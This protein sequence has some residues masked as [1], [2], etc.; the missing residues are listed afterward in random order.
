MKLGMYEYIMLHEPI[1]AEY[2]INP[3][4][5]YVSVCFSFTVA[6]EWLG[7]HVPAATNTFFFV[8]PFLF[9]ICI[10]IF[11]KC[12]VEMRKENKLVNYR[13]ETCSSALLCPR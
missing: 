2:P 10:N 1:S 4:N 11:N 13:I 3:S 9:V 12:C 7:R 8:I 5:Q 6:R